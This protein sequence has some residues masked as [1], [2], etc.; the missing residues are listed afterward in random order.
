MYQNAVQLGRYSEC[1]LYGIST[2]S[3]PN[4]RLVQ[5]AKQAIQKLPGGL[6]VKQLPRDDSVKQA[7]AFAA[8]AGWSLIQAS[9]AV[10]Q[11]VT[12]WK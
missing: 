4:M 9:S 12:I 5:G 11:L 3:G 1:T 7:A 10:A 6:M 8:L 2:L